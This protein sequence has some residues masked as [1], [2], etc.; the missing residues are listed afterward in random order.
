MRSFPV[1]PWH[2][3]AACALL[4]TACGGEAQPTPKASL[5]RTAPV[6]ETT[7]QAPVLAPS[8]PS[9]V[10]AQATATVAPQLTA[11]ANADPT[12]P[13]ALQALP[14]VSE[15]GTRVAVITSYE[16]GLRGDQSSEFLILSSGA[17]APLMRIAIAVP[18]AQPTSAARASRLS[19]AAAAMAPIRWHKLHELPTDPDATVAPRFLGVGETNP[20]F[21]HDERA[22]VHF[23]E[24]RL[25]ITLD[26]KATMRTHVGWSA[27]PTKAC[28]ECD[29]CPAPLAELEHAYI[30][31]ELH[32]ALI[33][34]RYMSA[35][36]V[37]STPD[38]TYH[39]VRF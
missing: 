20:Q 34:I 39:A 17:D 8:S 36:D 15:D 25:S 31:D 16:D 11:Q 28:P 22:E 32:I 30:D 5:E 7:E 26:G 19:S 21:G 13:P 18:E 37:C 33:V 35:S 2:A 38:E 29:V 9:V 4:L 3:N 6:T 24:P 14:A 27:R 1:F 12:L 10:G 23:Q